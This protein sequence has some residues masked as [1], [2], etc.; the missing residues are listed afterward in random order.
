MDSPQDAEPPV[1]PQRT[2]LALVGAPEHVC[3]RYRLQAF[4]PSLAEAGWRLESLVLARNV[5]PALA[6]LG[7][8]AL[9]D[10]VVLQRHLLP[11]WRIELIR[12]A[13]RLLLFD[14]DDAVFFRDSNHRRGPRSGRRMRRFRVTVRRADAV[15]AG[16]RFLIRHAARATGKDKIRFFPTCVDL[17]A[18]RSAT[19]ERRS[20]QAKLV[21]IGSRSTATSLLEGRPGLELA[22][23]RLG[24]LQLRLI[25]DWF[26]D[27]GPDITVER[28]AWT[29]AGEVDDLAT[30]DIGLSWLP[31]HPWSRGKC[32]LKVLQ[33]MAAGLPVVA[34]PV[35]VHRELI[36]H[37][38][39]GLLARTPEEWAE[40]IER[41]A[42]SPEL[43]A[44]MGRAGRERVAA[45]YSVAQWGPVLA[46]LLAELDADK[47]V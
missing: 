18:Y 35:G 47:R 5:L 36:E 43:R 9:A 24:G 40:A 23:R 41:L 6:E 27:L 21:W 28:R 30:A 26:P 31:D 4:A 15:L 42:A 3:Y 7:K 29:L 17:S 10:A 32:G 19:H 13:A 38:R 39:T 45:H 25:C 20:D 12:R 44:E 16:N 2:L 14:F 22:S 1:R 46:R 11:W 34:N 37:G 33:Y 8:I